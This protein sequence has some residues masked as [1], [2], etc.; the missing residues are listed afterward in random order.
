MTDNKGVNTYVLPPEEVEK[1]LQAKFGSKIEPTNQ[2][3]LAKQ[4][5]Q[6][7]KN[8]DRNKA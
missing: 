5:L 3:K 2:A 8:R 1:M 6:R 7:N 4:H